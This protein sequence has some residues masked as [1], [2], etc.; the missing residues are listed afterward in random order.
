MTIKGPKWYTGRIQKADI[1]AF[2]YWF[3]DGFL[4]TER[5]SVALEE[6]VFKLEYIKRK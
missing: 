6:A 3:Y 1:V 4:Y 5:V 2:K